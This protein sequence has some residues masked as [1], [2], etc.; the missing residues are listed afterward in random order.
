METRCS[1][2]EIQAQG[3]V[4]INSSSQSPF[5][6]KSLIS[7]FFN[8]EPG[9]VIVK[10]P[11]VGGAY[12]GKTPV[13][14]ELLAFL[15]SKAVGGRA[16]KIINTREEDLITSPVHI[17][18]EAKVELGA[19]KD[20]RLVASKIRFF[21]DGGAYSD[22]AVI[23]SRAAAVDCTGPYNVE[24]VWCDSLCMYTNHPYA[25]AF[26]G[27][28]HCE[29]TFAIER[30]MDLLAEKLK[31]DPLELRLRNA[32]LPGDNSPTQTALNSS[33]IGN[34]PKCI[35]KLSRLMNWEE[36]T[37]I[38]VGGDKVRTKGISCFWKTSSTAFNAEGG[39][40][41]TF[42][43]DGS[44]NL[45]CGAVEMGQGIK[46]ALSQILAEKM[47]MDVDRIYVVMEVDTQTVP[48]HW[49]TA[50]SRTIML[51]GRAVISAAED[52]I[53]QLK[54]TAA[55][56]LN[57]SPEELKVED[58]KVVRILDD[59]SYIPIK[60]IALGYTYP[61][62][63][64]IEGQIIGRGKYI[65]SNLSKMNKETGKGDPGT[66]WTLGAQGIEVEFD[67]V[68]CN[69]KLIKAVS[70]ID[71]GKVINLGAAVGQV[72]GGMN[73][74]LSFASREAFI[75]TEQGIIQNGNLR[76][77]K[78]MRYGE[79]PKYVVDFVE[80]PNLEGPYGARGVGEYGVIGM[81]AA[82]ANSLSEAA[83]VPLNE[84]PLMPEF[85]WKTKK[86]GNHDSL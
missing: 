71:A 46:T 76:T 44:I 34:L 60:E 61:N 77:Y 54:K 62:G 56:V 43:P 23:I 12:G 65:V 3:Q 75:F 28:G 52:A 17:G 81:P 18:L 29:L 10:I 30:T 85:I 57:G 47:K 58:E 73:L 63:N 64:S 19:L 53:C 49:K 35:E 21:F 74:G 6:I 26:R 42:N 16:V 7:N 70:V 68:N 50:A 80:T 11:F 48:E 13:Q 22:R 2:A 33:N 51:V 79:N 27:F 78:P 32:I 82:L 8:V 69:Y 36:G 9:N 39:V 45:I 55:I 72:A 1:I 25:T 24:N 67:R 66:E 5:V 20:G 4:I 37:S 84:L 38:E 14:L 41:L 40:I 15:A 31:M 83:Q 86:G 59:N